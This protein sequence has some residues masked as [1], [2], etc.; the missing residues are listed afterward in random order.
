MLKR[1]RAEVPRGI[2]LKQASNSMTYQVNRC[3][4]LP[5]VSSYLRFQD[6][7]LP[8][9]STYQVT[10]DLKL[11]EVSSYMRYQDAC[12][13]VSEQ[14]WFLCF[15]LPQV[16]TYLR[17]SRHLRWLTYPRFQ[18]EVPRC[19][20]YVIW[21]N[22]I[23]VLSNHL[24]QRPI[25][26]HKDTWG[27]QVTWGFDDVGSVKGLCLPPQVDTVHFTEA[28]LTCGQVNGKALNVQWECYRCLHLLHSYSAL[29]T[30]ATHQVWR[31]VDGI[32]TWTHG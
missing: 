24:R 7:K 28:G 14:V 1:Y 27:D 12:G 13:M 20:W 5:E 2:K 9:V 3:I 11:T 16:V 4:K 17:W 26:G 23:P 30:E 8:E 29:K 6:I 31:S 21:T 22:I 32:Q 10:T 18:P 19:L 25:W 15:M